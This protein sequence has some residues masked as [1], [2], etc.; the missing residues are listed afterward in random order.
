MENL[1]SFISY[2]FVVTFTPGPNNIMS[3]INATQYGYKKTL[4]FML[5][6]FTGFFV[7][8]LVSSFANLFLVKYI[9]K[10]TIYMKAL[11]GFYM[12]YLA[13][14]ILKPKKKSNDDENKTATFQT[15]LLLQLVNVKVI[16][17]CLTVVSSFII[18][19]FQST[20][21]LILFSFLLA[22][23]AFVS[24]NCWALFGSLF[25][26]YINKYQKSFNLIMALLL[27]Y[28]A[29]MITGVL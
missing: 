9:P 15:G 26:Q 18:P 7:L 16:L 25:N 6:V 2:V 22:L 17:Y 8:M 28:S 19:S 14:N 4:K 27:I 3:M 5:G 20:A 24:V 12:L 11:G 10:I 29:L 13:K 21:I 1:F 23:T